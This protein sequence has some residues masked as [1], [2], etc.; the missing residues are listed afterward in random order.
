MIQCSMT[1]CDVQKNSFMCVWDS[2]LHRTHEYIESW[3]DLKTHLKFNEIQI[4]NKFIQK[5]NLVFLITLTDIWHMAHFWVSYGRCTIHGSPM[6][7]SEG[8][9]RRWEG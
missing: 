7:R 5:S 2:C 4:E 8:L 6:G 1:W 3:V 9:S